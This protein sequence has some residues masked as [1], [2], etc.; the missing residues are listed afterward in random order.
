MLVRVL[1]LGIAP[2]LLLFAAGCPKGATGLEGIGQ[3]ERPVVPRPDGTGWTLVEVDLNS[4]GAADIFNYYRD[5]AQRSGTPA[6]RDLDLN[7]DGRVDVVSFYDVSGTLIREELDGDFDGRVDVID[8]YQGGR[9]VLSEV[10]TEYDGR[11]DLWKFYEGDAVRKRERDTSGDGRVDQW[12]QLDASGRVVLVERDE[13]G[14]G[15][16]DP[17]TPAPPQAE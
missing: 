17:T 9:R 12:E 7:W 16:P 14:D 13:D 6:R 3:A 1:R 4:D 5:P 11:V 10:D 8:H 2:W 15:S